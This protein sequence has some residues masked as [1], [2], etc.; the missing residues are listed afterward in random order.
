MIRPARD[1]DHQRAAA[2]LTLEVP[3]VDVRWRPLL[4][5]VI[6]THLVTRLL[7][8]TRKPGRWISQRG[9]AG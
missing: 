5:V 3:S 8:P 2:C 9:G 4:S 1:A 7:A 6:V